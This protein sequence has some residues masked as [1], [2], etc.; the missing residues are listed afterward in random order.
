MAKRKQRNKYLIG[1]TITNAVL[2]GISLPLNITAQLELFDG[3]KGPAYTEEKQGGKKKR[4]KYKSL[5]TIKKMNVKR[6]PVL[7]DADE[8]ASIRKYFDNLFREKKIA[9]V[10][11]KNNTF[12]PTDRNKIL[13][14]FE[15][16]G[17]QIVFGTPEPEEEKLQ[18]MFVKGN[19]SFLITDD[20][21][22][23][24]AFILDFALLHDSNFQTRFSQYIHWRE[25]LRMPHKWYH[26][27]DLY[28]NVETIVQ[29]M[30]EMWQELTERPSLQ[31]SIE[32]RHDGKKLT[33]TEWMELIADNLAEYRITDAYGSHEQHL[34]P[35]SYD[36]PKLLSNLADEMPH[37]RIYKA[38]ALY[39]MGSTT[40]TLKLGKEKP[41]ITAV[42][43][44]EAH[45]NYNEAFLAEINKLFH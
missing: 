21:H 13:D 37:D 29:T 6:L 2:H 18:M 14:I 7:I 25:M 35:I 3:E 32:V 4:K 1:Q 36:H 28:E 39:L 44:W 12:L 43:G 22:K 42:S 23:K 24:K 33:D 45:Q 40:L 5:F 20:W 15:K 26:S 38:Y 27:E 41:K 19:R 31:N 9:L 8:L 10:Q 16:Y 17:Y 34:R 11:E 30:D